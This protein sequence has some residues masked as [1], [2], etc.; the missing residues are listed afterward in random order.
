[1]VDE[2]VLATQ[3]W[4]NKNYINKHGFNRVEENGRTGWDTVYGL[5]RALQIEMGIAEPSDNFGPST[6]RLYNNK[7]IQAPN[8]STVT[9]NRFAILQGALWCK[10]YDPKHYGSLDN[11]Y[12]QSVIDAVAQLQEDAGLAS[13]GKVINSDLMKALLSMD[14]FRIIPGSSGSDTV[15][16]F[17]Q[18]LNR[19]YSNYF[20]IIPCDGLYDR[21]TNE[22]SIYMLQALEGMP[23]SVANGNFG[24][25]T[26]RYCPTILYTGGESNYSG[27]T[28]TSS[29]IAAFKKLLIFSLYV[30]G[31]G[32]GNLTTNNDISIWVKNFQNKYA[33]ATTGQVNL[34]TWLS[35]L[36]S[37]GDASRKGLACDTRFE[38][39]DAHLSNLISNGYRYVGRYLTGGDFKEIRVGELER[40]IA[41][42]LSVFPIFEEGG[43]RRTYFDYSQGKAD[44]ISAS[45]AAQ[46]F[47]I[48]EQSVIY[49]AVDFDALDADVTTNI[50]PYFRGVFENLHGYRIG[51]YGARNVCSRVA[52][53]GYSISSFVAD[54]SSGF[55]GNMGYPIPNNWAFDQISNLTIMHNGDQLEIDNDITSSLASSHSVHRLDTITDM[56][57]TPN[58]ILAFDDRGSFQPTTNISDETIPVY[59]IDSESGVFGDKIGDI[60]PKE[61]YIRRRHKHLSHLFEVYISD[62]NGNAIHGG[63]DPIKVYGKTEYQSWAN[64][65]ARFIDWNA[66]GQNL[67]PT[68]GK[69]EQIDN[70]DYVIFTLRRHANWIS[71]VNGS[72]RVRGTIPSGA[73]VAVSSENV[74]GNTRAMYIACGY[75]R[76]SAASQWVP[77]TA[78]GQQGASFI[79][80]GFQYGCTVDKRLLI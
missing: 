1:M 57:P 16:Q 55:S 6:T 28:Y 22:A 51:V 39:T 56:L 25:S 75:Y 7:P 32:S 59:A 46:K 78:V 40:I 73:Q 67:V 42:G 5:L 80:F 54:M 35:L 41:A 44:A 18:M 53:A 74:M 50:L 34:S 66:D 10:G 2:M 17:Q 48:P 27:R 64:Q 47:G 13:N 21:K 15:R 52:N 79:D 37:T 70:E 49:F 8:N 65:Q 3:K 36:T 23:T 63:Y 61:S 26:R 9:D 33:L 62:D 29:E 76:S 45:R 43:Y 12:D 38:I 72:T 58:V 31:F 14:Q 69:W 20:G 68:Q 71:T 60:Y 19:G 11:H 30:N 77:M 4:L 24:P